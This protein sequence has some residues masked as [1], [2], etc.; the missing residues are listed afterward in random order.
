MHSQRSPNP[1][2]N[3]DDSASSSSA[4]STSSGT[5]GRFP[6]T[7]Y[8]SSSTYR[9]AGSNNQYSNKPSGSS[10]SALPSHLNT[11]STRRPSN[12]YYGSAV[13]ST[14]VLR[15][16]NGEYDSKPSK[17]SS[18]SRVPQQ[19][20][21]TT[22][23]YQ[24]PAPAFSSRNQ[25]Q[26]TTS[27]YQPPAPAFAPRAMDYNSSLRLPTR[28]APSSDSNSLAES[29]ARLSL[30]G[31][32]GSGYNQYASSRPNQLEGTALDAGV[33]GMKRSFDG[34]KLDVG[35][36]AHKV[37]KKLARKILNL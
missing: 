36:A 32:G 11:T 6:S 27:S 25:Q 31:G 15:R 24:P 3:D 10:A 20:Q 16:T 29:A 5:G 4:S 17:S 37:K 23:S 9:T 1:F 26:F 30:N 12:D 28:A 13:P 7:A 14:S 8:T 2:P 34:F 21:F 19:S 35:F 22:S 18:K 33:H